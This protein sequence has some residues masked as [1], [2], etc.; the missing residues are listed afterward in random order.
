MAQAA[1]LHTQIVLIFRV[2][3]CRAFQERLLSPRTVYFTTNKI[4]WEC[5]EVNDCEVEEA[6]LGSHNPSKTRYLAFEQEVPERRPGSSGSSDYRRRWHDLVEEYTKTSLTFLT[7]KLPALQGIAKR[8]QTQRKSAYYA[9][10]WEDSLCFDLLWEVNLHLGAIQP[11]NGVYRAPSWSWV[12]V[13][14]SVCWP[15]EEQEDE[16][17]ILTVQTVAAGE[18]TLGE[19]VGGVL[20][21]KTLCIRATVDESEVAWSSFIKV[22]RN[23]IPTKEFTWKQDDS[24]TSYRD[25]N[26]TL[27]LITSSTAY[28]EFLVL[29]ELDQSPQTFRRIGRATFDRQ[30]DPYELFDPVVQ[31]CFERGKSF[32][33]CGQYRETTII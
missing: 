10:L 7:D 21:L 1:H 26:V 29:K 32:D 5:K 2:I 18:D 4:Y 27:C 16:A 25:T 24:F 17:K 31:D 23:G 9:G 15:P 30:S 19:I 33:G 12:S 13:T 11:E 8:V 22:S 6:K 14:S 20:K 3:C 28:H